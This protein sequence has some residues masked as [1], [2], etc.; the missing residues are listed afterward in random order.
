MAPARGAKDRVQQNRSLAG[1]VPAIEA[2]YDAAG[3]GR[4]IA[5]WTPPNSG[6]NRALIGLNVICA[7]AR[8]AVRNDWAGS[9]SV[10]KWATTLIGIGIK[11]RFDSLKNE[12]RRKKEM[13]AFADWCDVAD[14]DGVL[15]FHGLQ[16][17]VVR[18]WLESGECFARLRDRHVSDDLDVPFQAQLL[19]ADFV[20]YEL[21]TDSRPGL[22]AGNRIR[23]G[24]ELTRDG[25]RA[26]YWMHREHPG[27][28]FI[29]RSVP[30]MAR[31]IIPWMGGKRRLADRIIPRFRPHSEYEAMAEAFKTIEGKALVS[32][33]DHPA[34]REC[35]RD[36][37]MES[38]DIN[39][40]VG[41]GAKA[42]ARKELVI[43]SW[44]QEDEPAGL[45]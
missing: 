22:V 12:S 4:R 23:Q 43:W 3:R 32:I 40:T 8:D 42:A 36:F 7:L 21:D 17:L 5:G 27:D 10:T 29:A 11:P 25:A 41:G 30:S 44:N 6:P 31:P 2:R 1:R 28:M 26:A 45:F 38:L 16:T 33:N 39:Y 15:N 14:A 20:P 19:E 24:I 35:F 34:V 18:G 13:A 37:H 9:T